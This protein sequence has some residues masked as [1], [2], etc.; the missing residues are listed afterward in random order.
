MPRQSPD[1]SNYFLSLCTFARQEVRIMFLLDAYAPQIIAL[2]FSSTMCFPEVFPGQAVFGV[3][4]GLTL[5][6]G[7]FAVFVFGLSG[8]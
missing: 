5:G 6:L 2:R 4:V 7:S 1:F 8:F 3:F